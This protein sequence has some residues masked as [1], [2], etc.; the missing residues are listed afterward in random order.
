[1]GLDR[2]QLVSREVAEAPEPADHIVL[3]TVDGTRPADGGRGVDDGAG[4]DHLA[5]GD[6]LV[7]P[8]ARTPAD[9]RFAAGHF[10]TTF[11]VRLA[12]G[13]AIGAPSMS[14][15]QTTVRRGTLTLV[16]SMTTRSASGAVT[17][18]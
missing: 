9:A 1:M 14:T 12:F 15:S 16:L 13:A 10:V 18:T 6:G 17:A 4:G 8:L 5:A 3:V 11:R 2:G 7:A